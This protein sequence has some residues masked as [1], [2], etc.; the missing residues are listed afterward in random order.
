MGQWREALQINQAQ[1]QEIVARRY[2]VLTVSQV[3]STFLNFTNSLGT[4]LATSIC[5][6][7][8]TVTKQLQEEEDGFLEGAP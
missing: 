7:W 6:F 4:A 5:H 2:S 3:C 8:E 1:L